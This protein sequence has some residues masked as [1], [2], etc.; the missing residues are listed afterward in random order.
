LPNG[1]SGPLCSSGSQEYVAFWIDYGTGWTYAGTTSVNLPHPRTPA[2]GGVNYSV[3]LA[4]DLTA[5]HKPCHQ[6]PVTA[7]V[8]AILSWNSAPP[9]GNPNY[10]PHWGNRLETLI[11]IKPGPV[12]DP[13]PFLS[14]VGDVP[15]INIDANGKANG[16][17]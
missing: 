2:V 13:V 8:R 3:F 7:R 14:S 15:E 11:H 6:G 9:P 5:G 10:R 17:A 4:V 12:L 1:F 16:N